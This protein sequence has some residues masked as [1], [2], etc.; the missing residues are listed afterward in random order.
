MVRSGDTDMT[1]IAELVRRSSVGE[2]GAWAELQARIEPEITAIARRHPSLR[3][4]GLASK[5]DDIAEVVVATLERLAR[6]DFK[7]L[8]RFLEQQQEGTPMTFD[9]WLY[10]A[11]DFVIREHVRRRFGRAP[12]VDADTPAS[13]RPSKRELQ[14]HAARLDDI[15]PERSFLS[16]MGMTARLTVAEIFEHI[17]RDFT[18]SEVVA[19][20]MYYREDRSFAEIAAALQFEDPEQAERLVR[21]LNARLRYRFSQT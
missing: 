3:N 21:K 12:K 7:N 8:K 20:R 18:P 11:V 10:G 4:K 5:V 15:P 19:M 6:D 13:V 14:S 16:T 2:A 17:A 9:S 1:E